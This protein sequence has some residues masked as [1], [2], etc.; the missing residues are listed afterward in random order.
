M[1]LILKGIN[2][3]GVFN[4]SGARNFFSN[5]EIGHGWRQH[6]LLKYM[7]GYSWDG[8]T[9][10]AKTTTLEGRLGHLN[11]GSD[12]Q[13]KSF[14]PDC[15]YVDWTKA[16]VLNDVSLSG[17]GAKAL[18]DYCVWQ[19][20][21]RPFLISFMSVAETDEAIL[22]ETTKFC[23]LIDQHRHCFVTKFGL[24][25][26]DSC[27]NLKGHDPQS[28]IAGATE[29]LRAAKRIL[30]D[31]PIV[32]KINALTSPWVAKQITDTGCCDA[33][34]VSNTIPWRKNATWTKN[35][36]SWINW[37]ALFGTD[38]SP[39]KRRGYGNGGLSGWPLLEL[40]IDWVTTFRNIGAT[41]PVKA[42]GGIQRKKD[43]LMVTAA[44]ANAIELG[45]IGFLKSWR[46][47]GL[48]DYGN[49]IIEQ[50]DRR[51]N[52]PALTR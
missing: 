37:R 14:I 26:N 30:P 42:G 50:D 20:L 11:L 15:V 4:S 33:A 48:I 12:L 16:I 3:G 51:I 19:N 44:G 18:L 39:L 17:P 36:K 21:R 47:G 22:E 7:P 49:R 27:P 46:L 28:R 38:I 32:W 1:S 41:I 9:F 2:F 25:M 6:R 10:I 31:I 35:P 24:E 34:S 29:R 13:P 43:V 5:G 40:V 8:S 52:K 23:R 45:T